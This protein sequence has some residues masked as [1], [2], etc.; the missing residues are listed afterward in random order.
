MP[1]RVVLTIEIERCITAIFS[2]CQNSTEFIQGRI[3]VDFWKN[4]GKQSVA[5]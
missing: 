2:E 1:V 3:D 4:V 5:A